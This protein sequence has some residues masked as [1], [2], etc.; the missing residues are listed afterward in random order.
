MDEDPIPCRRCGAAN[1]PRNRF[2]GQCGH[3]SEGVP[4]GT[5][6]SEGEEDRDRLLPALGE[7]PPAQPASATAAGTLARLGA[8]GKPLAAGA[9]VLAAEAAAIWLARRAGRGAPGPASARHPA[10]RA[11]RAGGFEPEGYYEEILLV[12]T[13]GGTRPGRLLARRSGVFGRY[14]GKR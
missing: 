2:C 3:P 7:A 1:P 14:A 12:V 13:Q 9:L 8:V 10:D 5:V 4:S 11:L 6:P